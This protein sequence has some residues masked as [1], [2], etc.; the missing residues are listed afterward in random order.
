MIYNILFKLHV[1]SLNKMDGSFYSFFRYVA[2]EI[3]ITYLLH[4][5]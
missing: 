4:M 5:L 1:I 3:V 2:H